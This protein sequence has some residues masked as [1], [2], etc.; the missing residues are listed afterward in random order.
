MRCRGKINATKQL[1]IRTVHS[2]EKVVR[3]G[4]ME[5]DFL[6]REAKCGGRVGEI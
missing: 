5:D 1:E 3:C 2:Y 4:Y 6:S